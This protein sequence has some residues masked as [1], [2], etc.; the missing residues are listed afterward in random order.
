[1]SARASNAGAALFLRLEPELDQAAAVF[2]NLQAC[3]S[4]FPQAQTKG[5]QHEQSPRVS[6]S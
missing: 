6:D 2:R 5:A 4:V 3:A 1:V